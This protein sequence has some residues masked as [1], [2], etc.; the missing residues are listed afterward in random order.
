MSVDDHAGSVASSPRPDSP[1][2]APLPLIERRILGVLVEKQKTSKSADSY[3]LTLNALVNGCNQKSNRD[4]V[5]DLDEFDVE[6]GL[7]SLQKKGL[8]VRIT[9]GRAE[10]FKHTLYENWTRVGTELAVLAELLLRGPQ[11]KGDLRG[12]AARMDPIDTLETLDTILQPLVERRLVVFLTDPD[13]RGAVLTH[14]FHTPD[15]LAHLKSQAANAPAAISE[16]HSPVRPSSPPAP[17]PDAVSDMEARLTSV[18][19]DALSEIDGLKDRVSK[20]EQTLA[21]VRKQFGLG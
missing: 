14:G 19:S 11:T 13:R 15:E 10:R 7:T 4:P 5:L 3:P 12:R 21:D 6:Q 2:F 9:G 16:V 20:L 8:M 18:I 1:T 17:T